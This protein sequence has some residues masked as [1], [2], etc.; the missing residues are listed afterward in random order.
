MAEP[1]VRFA[2]RPNWSRSTESGWHPAAV[3]PNHPGEHKRHGVNLQTQADPV[4]R[5]V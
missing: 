1:L 2:A 4:S 3:G 5:L